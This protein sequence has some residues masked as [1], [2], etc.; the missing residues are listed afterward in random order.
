LNAIRDLRDLFG[1]VTAFDKDH[2]LVSTKTCDD[3]GRPH[4]LLKPG[5][6]PD[7]ELI[8]YKMTQDCR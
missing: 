3:I 1:V 7:Q 2:E 4:T 8:A 5:R 6:D